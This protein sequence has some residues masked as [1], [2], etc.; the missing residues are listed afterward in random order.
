MNNPLMK[1]KKKIGVW[2]MYQPFAVPLFK[3]NKQI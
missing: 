2:Q 3:V 1:V